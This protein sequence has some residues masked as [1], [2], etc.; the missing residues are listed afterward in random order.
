MIHSLPDLDPLRVALGL[1]DRPGTVLLHT[2]RPWHGSGRSFLLLDPVW[3]LRVERGSLVDG[4]GPVPR[5]AAPAAS[6]GTHLEQ[7]RAMSGFAGHEDLPLLAGFLG[8]ETGST[9]EG[10]RHPVDPP[11]RLPDAWFGCFDAVLVF[12][13]A[14][15]PRLC[16]RDRGEGGAR[17][18]ARSAE[19]LAT[20]A[21]AGDR[22]PGQAGASG[23]PRFPDPAWHRRAMERIR[24]HLLAGDAYQ[25][26]LTG[27]A[28]AE[29]SQDPFIHFLRH[30]AA[31]PVPFAAY[32]MVDQCAVTSHSPERLLRIQGPTAE[33]AP[34]K[35][36]LPDGPTAGRDLRA[37]EKDRAEHL[38][39]VDLCRND[40]GRRARTGSVEVRGLMEELR[41][42]G[43]VHLVSRIRAEVRPGAGGAL[44]DALFPGGSITG[45]PKARAMEI[46]TAC[47]RS[48][49]GPYTGSI[50]YL[51]GGGD[52]DFNIAIRTAIWQ[53]GH[54]HFGCG[55]GIV[56]DS[57]PAAEYAEARLKAA[58]FFSSLASAHR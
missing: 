21:A 9:R 25:I 37:S 14:P 23:A 11:F 8:Y 44:L 13:D 45:A 56:V 17:L 1:A 50:G 32:I 24:T 2:Q 33:T 29:T 26:N 39:I 19:L 42:Q 27:F 48:A 54:V 30:S 52:L 55:G 43:V 38:M 31:N 20:I 15:G 46:I 7:L 34:I 3:S 51:T 10:C 40:L 49:R 18:R 5:P 12:G 57:D 47:E 6:V 41:V 35:G 36:T 22:P 53:E 58:S 4:H 16:V 28:T